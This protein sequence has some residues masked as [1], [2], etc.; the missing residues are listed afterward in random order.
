MLLGEDSD[1]YNLLNTYLQFNDLNLR[2][3][4]DQFCSFRKS[5]KMLFLFAAFS[6]ILLLPTNVLSLFYAISWQETSISLFS[7]TVLGLIAV[8]ILTILYYQFSEEQKRQD[9]IS[10]AQSIFMVLL[11][12]NLCFMSYRSFAS[13]ECTIFPKVVQQLLPGLQCGTDR[14]MPGELITFFVVNPI[15]FS[16]SLCESRLTL[17]LAWIFFTSG[18]MTVMS[19]QYNS[20]FTVS[21]LLWTFGV[22]VFVIELH[23]QKLSMFLT[24]HKLKKTLEENERIADEQYSAELRHMIGNVAHDL[25]TVSIYSLCSRLNYCN[26]SL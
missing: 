7:V 4:F 2:L 17:I 14:H 20:N 21:I 12:L 22:V 26:F 19:V 8:A 6:I 3:E 5:K 18:I 13:E 25:K 16:V 10:Y 9:K 24:A 23:M 11:S 1:I 15:I